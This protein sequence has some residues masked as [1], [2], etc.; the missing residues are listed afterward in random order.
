MLDELDRFVE[1]IVAGGIIGG[2]TLPIKSMRNK[3]WGCPLFN[4]T[5]PHW[6]FLEIIKYPRFDL[7]TKRIYK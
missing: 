6:R 2:K 3:S 1:L 5:L 7:K 4:A